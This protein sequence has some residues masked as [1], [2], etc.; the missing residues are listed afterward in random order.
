MSHHVYTS[1]GFVID[2]KPN[3]EAGKVLFLFTRE[4]GM[5]AAIAQGIRLGVS[6]LRYHTQDFSYAT[7]SLVKGKEMWRLTGATPVASIAPI[8]SG[9]M[10]GEVSDDMSVT[11]DF[12]ASVTPAHR[13]I[14]ARVFSL[15]RRLLHGE[16]KNEPLFD[17]VLA[18]F[19][20]MNERGNAKGDVTSSADLELIECVI[21]LRVLHHLGYVRPSDVLTPFLMQDTWDDTL[22][23]VMRRDKAF[24]VK[25]IN[26]GIKASQL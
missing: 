6:K 9:G 20:Y 19:T 2:S 25:E 7:F 13:A 15:L 26:A 4:L 3:G 23:D 18:F 17:S 1:Q 12:S 8:V 10:S 11:D 5:V 14:Y 21:V 16:E 24:V 22:I